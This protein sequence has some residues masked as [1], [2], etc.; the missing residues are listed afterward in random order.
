MPHPIEA[1]I[2]G[3]KVKANIPW[4]IPPILVFIWVH[5]QY[6]YDPTL[7]PLQVIK[8]ERVRKSAHPKLCVHGFTYILCSLL[9]TG[10][11][12][13]WIRSPGTSCMRR[14]TAGTWRTCSGGI[15]RSIWRTLG[16]G[17]IVSSRRS[18]AALIS[19]TRR[20]CYNI[21]TRRIN[22]VVRRNTDFFS[23]WCWS[24]RSRGDRYVMASSNFL[25]PS[26]SKDW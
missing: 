8:V 19:I 1:W 10:T 5:L 24:S 14:T 2:N 11:L 15:P 22:S 20:W 7:W 12:A 21:V 3:L 25:I 13:S 26:T 23:G 17:W 4:I 16:A 18:W 6:T 9:T